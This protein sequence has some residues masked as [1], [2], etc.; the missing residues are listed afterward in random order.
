MHEH[1]VDHCFVNHSALD[2]LNVVLYR[3]NLVEGVYDMRWFPV[4][5][6]YR[7][8]EF[9]LGIDGYLVEGLDVGMRSCFIL[10]G[11]VVNSC[12]FVGLDVTCFLKLSLEP[13]SQPNSVSNSIADYGLIN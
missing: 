12:V 6:V 10:I 7:S 4:A 8:A 11:M 1:L 3:Q 5:L 2:Q 13:I 9:H